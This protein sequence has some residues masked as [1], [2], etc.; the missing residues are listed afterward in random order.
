[1]ETV[2]PKTP[3]TRIVWRR[4]LA[5]RLTA[6]FLLCCTLVFGLAIG[7]NYIQARAMITG[8]LEP[9]ARHLV[10]AAAARISARLGHGPAPE[11]FEITSAKRSSW[12]PAPRW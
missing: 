8:K 2:K 3:N 7:Y 6:V 10:T 11:L 1:M 12:A 9:T 4:R 5:V